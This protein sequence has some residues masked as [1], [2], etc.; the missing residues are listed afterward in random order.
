MAATFPVTNGPVRVDGQASL[1]FLGI[2]PF[3]G[4]VARQLLSVHAS[5]ALL[6]AAD[7][8]NAF[9]FA[10]EAVI[11][12]MWRPE[13]ALCERADELSYRLR[14]PWLPIVMEHP[15]IR[16]GPLVCPQ[17]GPCF[18]C[19]RRR[20]EQHD[21]QPAATAALLA[22]YAADSA[23]GP[24]GYLPHHARIAAGVAGQ[25][26]RGRPAGGLVQGVG[27]GAAAMAGQVTTIRLLNGSMSV[28]PVIACHDCD[29]CGGPA[30]PAGRLDAVIS[31]A[32]AGRRR[33]AGQHGLALA[34]E[35]VR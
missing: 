30:G 27:Q 31:A 21:T 28:S 14:V 23:A 17:T 1:I 24:G 10:R 3:G 26:I 11:V 9:A 22:A 32:V 15:V 20:R 19:Y 13:P 34:Q 5:S 6:T 4:R 16:V 29:R 7:I 18:R 8:R 33:P 2:G 35:A 12:A 25:L